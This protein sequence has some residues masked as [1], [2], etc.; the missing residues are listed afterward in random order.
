[1]QEFGKWPQSGEIDLVESRGNNPDCQGGSSSFASTLHFGPDW[2]H[3]AWTK[4][5]KEYT[6]PDSLGDDF[7]IY[8]LEWTKDGIITRIDDEEVLNYPFTTNQFDQGGFPKDAFN[9]WQYED[10]N[11]APFNKEFFL[12]LNVAVGGVNGYFPDGWCGK[13]YSDQDAKAANNFYD[14]KDSW[15][16]SWN[17]PSTNDSAMKIDWVKVYQ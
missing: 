7:H 5:H 9:P 2:K 13:P 16:P 1:M 8:E 6:H 15:Y 11:S 14:K 3:D 4:A 12:I 17:Y 10:D